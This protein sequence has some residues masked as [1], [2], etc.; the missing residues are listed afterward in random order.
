MT[1]NPQATVTIGST[2][3]SAKALIGASITYGRTN[4]TTQPGPGYCNVSLVDVNNSDLTVA[5]GDAITISA[6]TTTGSNVNLFGGTV[7]DITTVVQSS[8]ELGTY[9]RY[10][11]IGIGPLARLNRRLVGSAGY[12]SQYDG[13]RIDAIVSDAYAE[14][15]IEV[16][17]TTLAWNAEPA[18]LTWNT[19]DPVIGGIDRPGNYQLAAYADGE[20][21]ANQLANV[22]ANSGLGVLYD[23]P[24][25]QINY[26][27]ATHR[28]ENAQAN[29]FWQVPAEAVISSG[30]K[31]A[32][33]LGDIATAVQ[34]GY[35]GGTVTVTSPTSA[36]LYG[37][38]GKSFN[39]VLADVLDATEQA[40]RYLALVDQPTSQ[41]DAITLAL[42]EPNL[43][44]STINTALSVYQGQPIEFNDLPNALGPSYSGFVEGWTWRLG[45]YT[46]DLRLTISDFARSVVTTRWS[47]ATPTTKWNTISATLK[48]QEAI[49]V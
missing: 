40:D 45:R 49:V 44:A 25:N 26:D 21:L 48:W 1:W 15:W 12:V 5:I 8:N 38:V 19:Y 23:T 4:T 31:Q 36:G 13:D 39:T 17:P 9:L 32:S 41:F 2:N 22:A 6:K 47:A 14:R 28:Q 35:S 42:H 11:I 37:D 18:T 24:A 30:L 7:S 27:D 43:T 16:L 34:V 20:T 29:G 3:F 46:A 10:D 33:R